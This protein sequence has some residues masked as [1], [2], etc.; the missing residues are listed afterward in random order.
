MTIPLTHAV[1][2]EIKKLVNKCLQ[3]NI[4]NI[5]MIITLWSTSTEICCLPTCF[6][7]F[8]RLFVVCIIAFMINENNK[9]NSTN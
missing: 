1:M 3:I 6:L 7:L 2:D 9:Q 5:C 8:F 4:H